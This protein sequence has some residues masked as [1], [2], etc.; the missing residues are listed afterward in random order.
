MSAYVIADITVTDPEMYRGYMA[1]SGPAIAAFGG[2]FVVRG[3]SPVVLESDWEPSRMVVVEFDTVD[4]ARAW[5]DSPEYREA[6]DARAG[7]A[8]MRMVLVEGVEPPA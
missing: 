6:R 2:R 1:L 3:G 4:Q 7:A 8:R 5:Y